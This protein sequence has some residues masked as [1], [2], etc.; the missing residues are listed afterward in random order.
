[1]IK[2]I[3]AIALVLGALGATSVGCG[4]SHDN[5]ARPT[6]IYDCTSCDG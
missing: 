3:V 4:S 6:F 1:L 5:L 2:R